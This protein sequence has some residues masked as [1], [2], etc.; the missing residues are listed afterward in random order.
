MTLRQRLAVQYGLVVA[1]C[2]T[3]LA[4]LSHHEFVVE[5]RIRQQFNL[6]KAS[7][8][9]WRNTRRWPST[10]SSRSCSAAVGG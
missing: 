10:S 5:P 1:V 2:L 7:V 6:P 9:P 3:L 8:A 4:G